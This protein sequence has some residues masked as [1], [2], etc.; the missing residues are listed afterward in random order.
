MRVVWYENECNSVKNMRGCRIPLPHPTASPSRTTI[1]A[2]T[3]E[4]WNNS[5]S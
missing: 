1:T 3:N 5:Q 4:K 2:G